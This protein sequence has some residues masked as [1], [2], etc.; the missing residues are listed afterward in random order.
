VSGA[1]SAAGPNASAARETPT[2]RSIR[3]TVAL[4]G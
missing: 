4:S 1:A 2:Q 3:S